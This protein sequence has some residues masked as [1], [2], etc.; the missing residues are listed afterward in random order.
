MDRT[1]EFVRVVSACSFG[2]FL[3]HIFTADWFRTGKLGFRL[4][5]WMAPSVYMIPVTSLAVFILSFVVVFLLRKIPILKR[6]VP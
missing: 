4:N 5:S 1:R 6:L 2:I 3:I